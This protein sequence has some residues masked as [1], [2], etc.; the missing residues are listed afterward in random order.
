[1]QRIGECPKCHCVKKLT[2]HHIYP[3]RHRRSWRKW[4]RKET[5]LICRDCHDELELRIPREQQPEW[6]Y[7]HIVELF[8][9]TPVAV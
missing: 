1:M 5:V 4:Q 6:F 2:R 8:I 7:P 3:K 9:G